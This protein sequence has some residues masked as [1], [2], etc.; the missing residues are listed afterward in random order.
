[1]FNE[2]ETEKGGAFRPAF[3]VVIPFSIQSK[4]FFKIAIS[5]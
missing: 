2:K 1:M 3:F 5:Q 4:A